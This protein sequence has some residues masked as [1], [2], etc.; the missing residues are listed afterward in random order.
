M[1]KFKHTIPEVFQQVKV[2]KY[3]IKSDGTWNFG[4]R[5]LCTKGLINFKKE[6]N[7]KNNMPPESK[8]LFI[9][10]LE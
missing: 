2:D 5:I 7:L 8:T 6:K 9:E 3:I 1:F 10:A 4:K